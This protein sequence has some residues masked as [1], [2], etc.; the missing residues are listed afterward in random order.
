MNLLRNLI[1]LGYNVTK[2]RIFAR[3]ESDPEEAHEKFVRYADRIHGNHLDRLLFDCSENKLDPGFEISNAAGFNKNG[4]ISPVFLKY[5]GFDRVVV[6]TVTLHPWKGKPRPRIKRYPETNSMVNWM[7][8]PGVGAL[9]VSDNLL[10][11]Y[12]HRV[13]I[14]INLA[15]T[16]EEGEVNSD[17]EGTVKFTRNLPYVD[18]YELNISCPNTEDF[19]ASIRGYYRKSLSEMLS[20]IE[21]N[22]NVQSLWVKVSP[23]INIENIRDTLEASEKHDVKGFIIGNTTTRFDKRYITYPPNSIEIGG[24]SGDAVYEQSRNTQEMFYHEMKNM[25]LDYKLI[26]CGGINSPQRA[27]ERTMQK[28]KMITGIQIFTPLI[29]Q[30]PKLLRELRRA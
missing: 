8:L 24:A 29:F 15:P 7:G 4:N 1:D 17:L 23:D 25:D 12:N 30:G 13:P 20:V 28:D 22:K 19:D 11:Y 2:K 6:G 26:A 18:R 27:L 10:S 5:L 14:T 16:P 3:T 9:N 21:D